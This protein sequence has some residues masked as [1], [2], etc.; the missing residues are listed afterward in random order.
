MS[1]PKKTKKAKSKSVRRAGLID[2]DKAIAIATMSSNDK[3]K[4]KDSVPRP[5]PRPRISSTS[6]KLDDAK[7]L[8][9]MIKALQCQVVSLKSELDKAHAFNAKLASDLA[10]AQAKIATL[11]PTPHQVCP[12]KQNKTKQNK[13]TPTSSPT[14]FH[15]FFILH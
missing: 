7:E 13:K 15:D 2:K 1:E 6:H 8:H 5:R 9:Q 14:L 11:T 4:D 12:P 10:A 3:D